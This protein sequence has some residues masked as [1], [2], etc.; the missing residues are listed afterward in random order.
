MNL[1][2]NWQQII[3]KAWSVRLMVL[4]GLLSGVE[5]IL[6]L[7]TDTLPWPRWASSLLIAAV[8]GGGFVARIVA[9]PKGL[10]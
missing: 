5:A 1:V 7:V 10:P 6:P 2:H 9:Q 8:V 3:R 4:A